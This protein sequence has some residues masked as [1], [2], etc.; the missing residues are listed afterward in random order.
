MKLFINLI[1]KFNEAFGRFVNSIKI[2]Y[3]KTPLLW[4]KNFF[5]K[6]YQAFLE[7]IQ[8]FI[9]EKDYAKN[10][11]EGLINKIF[12]AF[13][14]SILIVVSV[15]SFLI[16][17]L[18][19]QG[20]FQDGKVSMFELE[21]LISLKKPAFTNLNEREF[22][23]PDVFVPVILKN[24]PDITRVYL[25]IKLRASNKFIKIY[26]TENNYLNIDKLIDRYLSTLSPIIPVFPLTDEGKTILKNKIK[27]ETDELLKILKIDG[28][29][30]EVI[31]QDMVAA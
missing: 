2:P 23:V 18:D 9:T 4:I 24:R 22:Y 16:Y 1:N 20:A 14:I 19:Q 27:K 7:K 15:L 11:F 5:S 29:I 30:E 31:I 21:K 10:L 8:R 26:F 3:P 13:T 25:D 17:K 6:L 28:E 12:N